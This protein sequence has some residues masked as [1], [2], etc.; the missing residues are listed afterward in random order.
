MKKRQFMRV[1]FTVG[2]VLL[3]AGCVTVNKKS[4]IKDVRYFEASQEVGVSEEI[5]SMEET[6]NYESRE[7]AEKMLRLSVLISMGRNSNPDYEKSLVMINRYMAVVSDAER[8]D[9]AGY[10]QH[11]LEVIVAADKRLKNETSACKRVKKRSAEL[12]KQNR[13]LKNK[14]DDL[15]NLE[16]RMEK[17]RLGAE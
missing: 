10:L 8:Q 14:I 9:F 15:K 6:I 11:L 3:I 16:I 12:L 1:V 4:D 17:Q 2:I 7:D 13:S 5:V